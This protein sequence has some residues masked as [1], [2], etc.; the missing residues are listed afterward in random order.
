M[1]LSPFRGAS[2]RGFTLIELLVV[3]AIIAILI[4][5][6]LPAV[7]KV[8]E[9]ANRMKCSNNL[10]QLALACHNY[11]DA[12]GSL[13]PSRIARDAY[14]T[15]VVCVMPF[16]EAD[17][18]YRLWD[19]RLGYADQTNAAR[20][21]T[22]KIM[23]CPSRGRPSLLSPATQNRPGTGLAF[24]S[25]TVRPGDDLS[26]ATGD[27]A[28]C[29]GN[30]DAR[31]QRGANGAIITGNVITPPPPGPQSGENGIDQPNN[32]PP[33][34]PL[35]PIISFRGYTDLGTISDGTSNTL[36]L[37]EK[38]VPKG[39]EGLEDSGDHSCYNGVGYNSAQRVAGP[40]F[41]LARDIFDR[42]SGFRDR[43]GGP[44]PSVVMFALCDGSIRG[45]RRSI[46]NTNLQR[47]AM[48]NDGQVITADY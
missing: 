9:A 44:H 27:Y 11:H 24:N 6:L 22:I 30:G 33:A 34:L 23:Y 43:F 3:I 28:C 2:R 14:A 40:S 42:S 4:G 26:G 10:K 37:G 15:W 48:R 45:L 13:P 35:V 25:G 19:I 32:N 8:R 1:L 41:P 17:N 5:L 29:A 47:L 7:Q 36:M 20:Q 39:R 38:H 18:P 46:D 12:N 31:N 21:A 16:M